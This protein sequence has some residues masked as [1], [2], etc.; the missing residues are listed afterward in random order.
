MKDANDTLI[1]DL[2]SAPRGRGRPPAGDRAMT[3][4]ERKAAQ[5][6]RERRTFVT[7][8]RYELEAIGT[9]ALLEELGRLV[10][11]GRPALARAIWEVLEARASAARAELHP[12]QGRMAAELARRAAE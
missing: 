9:D 11:G 7:Y 12:E 10:S 1:Q 4:A 6:E 2:I 8:Q 3:P 5:R